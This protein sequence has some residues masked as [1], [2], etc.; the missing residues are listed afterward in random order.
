VN[1]PVAPALARAA[2]S[3][4][5]PPRRLA[6]DGRDAERQWVINSS[7]RVSGL[8]GNHCV[9]GSQ[10]LTGIISG[11]VCSPPPSSNSVSHARQLDLSARCELDD[12]GRSVVWCRLDNARYLLKSIDISNGNEARWPAD[13]HS[14]S[15]AEAGT[16]DG[17]TH[18]LAR[19]PTTVVHLT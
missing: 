3:A 2:R 14:L 7:R 16:Y 8:S 5:R 10:P 13:W 17:S 19:W 9:P 12:E 6:N 18:H 4:V 1:G 15:V 11:A